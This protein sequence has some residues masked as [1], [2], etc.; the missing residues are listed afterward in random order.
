MR[1]SFLFFLLC[2]LFYPSI[3]I[4]N[5]AQDFHIISKQENILIFED[6]TFTKEVSIAIEKA[7]YSMGFPI[8]Y[9]SELEELSD[10]KVYVKKGRKYKELDYPNTH[11]TGVDIDYLNSKKIKSVEIPAG[12]EVKINYK[13]RCTEL[14]YFSDLPL[15]T[16][17][18]T[19]TINY[20]VSV[21][22]SFSFY[23]NVLDRDSL[24]YFSKD[25]IR[26]D[27]YTHWRINVVPNKVK[28][29]PLMYFGIYRNLKV[30]L[31]RTLVV[32]EQFRGNEMQYMNNWYLKK[33]EE[34][35][36]LNSNTKQKIDEITSGLNSSRAVI[37][38]L[39]EYVKRNF[40]YV[41]IEIGMGAFIPT[42]ANEVYENKQGDCKDLSNFLSEALSYKGIKSHIAMAATYDHITDCTFPSLC[43]ANHVICV[44]YIEDEN[45][46][47]MD[48]T[49]PIHQIDT[50]VQSI[51]E[52]TI[53][54]VNEDGGEYYKLDS[55]SP[56]QNLI[57][58]E[59]FLNAD[60]EHMSIQG[61]FEVKYFGISGNFLKRGLLS[62]DNRSFVDKC[63]KHYK[64]VFG[65]HEI[66][67]LDIDQN[68]KKF[69]ANGQILINGKQS[70]PKQF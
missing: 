26:D 69:Q 20:Q 68:Q 12:Y 36:R 22:N 40:K 61:N 27:E 47:I 4:S 43:S 6:S 65:N 70:C 49:D 38:T 58:Y 64:S 63:E 2:F 24:A 3:L 35:R 19:D 34:R 44:A 23:Y 25:S 10:V 56:Q 41:A 51:Q 59:V 9:D 31:V 21:P 67:N 52:R 18:D 11:E 60:S 57:D 54:V 62:S 28:A 66:S 53:F 48:P 1:N 5:K 55:F 13:I 8:F 29:D 30:P 7:E 16:Y 37:D 46:I 45:P 32:P 15:F 39:Y 42:D 33:V 50:P 17:D 14:M